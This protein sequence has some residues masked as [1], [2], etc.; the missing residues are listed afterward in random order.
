MK[1]KLRPDCETWSVHTVMCEG[2]GL[3]KQL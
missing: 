2:T 1:Q 3:L